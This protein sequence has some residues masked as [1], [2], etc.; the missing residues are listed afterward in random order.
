M[1]S[2][3]AGS[4]AGY[5]QN[6]PVV[7]VKHQLNKTHARELLPLIIKHLGADEVRNELEKHTTAVE[8]GKFM[9][10]VPGSTKAPCVTH[11]YLNIATDEA[12]RLAE[13]TGLAVEVVRVVATVYR[14]AVPAPVQYKF[15][16]EP[17]K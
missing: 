17:V 13:K 4:D 7:T 3:A 14:T 5:V 1:I 2:F 9:C 6:D 11:E 12:C 10:F 16:V 15:V 8:R